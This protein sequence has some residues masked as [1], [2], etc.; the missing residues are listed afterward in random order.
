MYIDDLILEVSADLNWV[1]TDVWEARSQWRDT[2]RALNLTEG[3]I[4]AVHEPDDGESLTVVIKLWMHSGKATTHTLLKALED[5]SVA[6]CDI[7][8]KLRKQQGIQRFLFV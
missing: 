1:R 2:G 5:N 4:S 8:N 7:A 6:R 3:T